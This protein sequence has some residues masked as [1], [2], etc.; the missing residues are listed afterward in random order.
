[1]TLKLK[2]LLLTSAILALS[3]TAQANLLVN[4]DF[5]ASNS[6]TATPPGWVNIGHSDGVI[7]YAAFGTPAYNGNYYYDLGGYGGAAGP[8]GDGIAQSFATVAGSSYL[9]TFGLSAENLSGSETL[10][11]AAGNQSIDYVLNP[12]GSGT[13]QRP[14]ATQTFT[15]TASSALTTLSFIHSAGPGG[16]NDPMIDGVSVV[17]STAAVPEPGTYAMMLA[18]MAA[19]GLGQLRRRR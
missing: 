15:F 9:V 19:F 6:P 2:S 16:N 10:T 4:G 17:L 3:G 18:G 5:E 8:I 7:A 12:D 13:F 11:V 1:M 14:F